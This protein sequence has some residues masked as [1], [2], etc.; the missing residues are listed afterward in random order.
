MKKTDQERIAQAAKEVLAD[1][2]KYC[3]RRLNVQQLAMLKSL[4]AIKNK[5]KYK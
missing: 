1:E 5:G 2:V 4:T 3:P